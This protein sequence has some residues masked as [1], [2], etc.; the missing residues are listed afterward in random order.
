MLLQDKGA[1]SPVLS[2]KQAHVIQPPKT[3][4][5]ESG[6]PKAMIFVV[7]GR[8]LEHLWLLRLQLEPH[9]CFA[10]SLP[11]CTSKKSGV[12]YSTVTNE[13]CCPLSSFQP[14][15]DFQLVCVCAG[16]GLQDPWSDPHKSL[17]H[18]QPATDSRL[19]P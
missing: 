6:A 9:E 10:S 11:H 3:D 17:M 8:P 16:G 14:F 1:V 5:R 13:R 2:W 15:C 7:H 18:L 4:P 12:P 19:A